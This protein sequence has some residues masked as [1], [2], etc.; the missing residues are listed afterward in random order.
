MR[1]W[2]AFANRYWP[3]KYVV[4]RDGQLRYVHFG[5]GSYDETEDVIRE[6]LGV[7]PGASRADDG[8]DDLDAPEPAFDQ[9]PELYLGN[10]RGTTA[11]PE[12]LSDPDGDGTPGGAATFTVPDELAGDSFALEGRWEIGEEAATAREPG[13]AI[14]LR[15]R[16]TEVNL[17]LAAG[18]AEATTVTVTIDDGEPRRIEVTDPDLVNLLTGGPTGEHTMRI[19]A[20]DAGLAAYAF[21]F[22]SG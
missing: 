17:V 10:L 14:V 8:A 5:E 16:G 9:T 13:A 15:Y 2:N 20:A 7:D 6:L 12:G 21:T 1:I 11:S 19:E 22:G 18:G 3:A 4:D